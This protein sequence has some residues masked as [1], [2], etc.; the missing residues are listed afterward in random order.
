MSRNQFSLQGKEGGGG[1]GGGGRGNA[2]GSGVSAASN[3]QGL[4]PL[5][6]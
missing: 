4:H 1:G 2:V 6:R 5:V 3:R